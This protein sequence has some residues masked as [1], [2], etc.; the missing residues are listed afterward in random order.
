MCVE[1]FLFQFVGRGY[2]DQVP[3]PLP[4]Y[5]V[6]F[7]TILQIMLFFVCVCVD[8]FLFLEDI[9]TNLHKSTSPP[10]LSGYLLNYFANHAIPSLCVCVCGA[11]FVS[12]YRDQLAEVHI[13]SPLIRAPTITTCFSLCPQSSPFNNV[14]C[15]GG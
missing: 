15:R 2:R 3:H 1:H 12:G 13:H 5:Q 9:E 8:H 14:G 11:L 6:A 7:L 10:H 4:T